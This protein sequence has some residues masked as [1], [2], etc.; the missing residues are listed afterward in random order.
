MTL[1]IRGGVRC[2]LEIGF[3]HGSPQPIDDTPPT[4]TQLIGLLL[5]LPHLLLLLGTLL[6][7]IFKPRETLADIRKWIRIFFGREKKSDVREQ[8]SE[9]TERS[10][11]G[12][13]NEETLRQWS[14][15]RR[16]VAIGIL[17]FYLLVSGIIALVTLFG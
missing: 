4:Q 8:K 14:N 2:C 15:E 13:P 6:S 1:L 16:S 17:Y 5:V 3:I 12:R 10:D 9:V 7:L 11:D